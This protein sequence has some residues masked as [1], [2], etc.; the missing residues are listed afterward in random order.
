M[1]LLGSL[2]WVVIG[3]V[4]VI[5]K[6]QKEE[7]FGKVIV[8]FISYILF[9]GL[10]VIIPYFVYDDEQQAIEVG[11]IIGFLCFSLPMTIFCFWNDI[12]N[13]TIV[14]KFKYRKNEE[15][16]TFC[17][18]RAKNIQQ[19]L[20]DA[21]YNV[22]GLIG[23]HGNF[24]SVEDGIKREIRN[25]SIALIAGNSEVVQNF[26][27]LYN[28]RDLSCPTTIYDVYNGLC[29][30]QRHILIGFKDEKLAELLEIPI[31]Y[32]PLNHNITK[33]NVRL[34]RLQCARGKGS[35]QES[36]QFIA[37]QMLTTY[38]IK[39]EANRQRKV[40]MVQRIL[41]NLGLSYPELF[42]YELPSD[43]NYIAVFNKC[44]EKQEKVRTLMDDA[45]YHLS[46]YLINKVAFD[47]SSPINSV[48]VNTPA[49]EL[50]DWLCGK[51]T[52]EISKMSWSDKARFDKMLGF[53][54]VEIPPPNDNVELRT[55][56]AVQYCLLKEELT[57]NIKYLHCTLY[58]CKDKENFNDYQ[59]DFNDF[60]AKYLCETDASQ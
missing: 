41:K 20:K 3:V 46:I 56:C 29:K 19:E 14:K 37:T 43:V 17:E 36:L 21:G 25:E 50:Y 27:P 10:L 55:I 38:D 58:F 60:V 42:Y 40:L 26:V 59:D 15:F 8:I 2:I 7:P 32:I 39:E 16:T 57:I 12:S 1:A 48:Y 6:L 18:K 52:A 35:T 44:F 11:R 53:P 22:G 28:N 54:L 4:Y 33:D 5:Y 47:P 23:V 9:V 31:E 51:R 49:E 13:L 45:G 24:E 34:N 30:L